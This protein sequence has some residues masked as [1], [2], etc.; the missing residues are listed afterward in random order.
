[1]KDG[2][3]NKRQYGVMRSIITAACVLVLVFITGYMYGERETMKTV[4]EAEA[5]RTAAN[6]QI[7]TW[8]TAI[9]GSQKCQQLER[10][11]ELE[12]VIACLDHENEIIARG[13]RE[14]FRDVPVEP[15]LRI[16]WNQGKLQSWTAVLIYNVDAIQGRFIDKNGFV[17]PHQ[18]KRG[19][20]AIFIGEDRG[21]ATVF[22]LTGPFAGELIIFRPQMRKDQQGMLAYHF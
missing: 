2:S 6:C 3:E 15:N 12:R 18:A 8:Q 11:Q 19:E 20:K 9:G 16:W 1:M 13:L 5:K 21:M 7:I 4:R 22:C 10:E 17:F 14:L